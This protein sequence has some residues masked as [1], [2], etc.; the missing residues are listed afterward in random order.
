MEHQHFESSIARIKKLGKEFEILVSDAEKALQLKEKLKK[1][2][3]EKKIIEKAE[4]I[5]NLQKIC[6]VNHIFY[7]EKKGLKPTESELQTAFGTTDFFDIAAEII[8]TG[9]IVLPSELRKKLREQ[10]LK[11]M[12]D[13][14][15]KNAVDPRT[16]SL[17]PPERIEAALKQV[18]AKIDEFKSIDEQLQS[19][20]NQ[21]ARILPIKLEI[22]KLEVIIPAAFTGKAYS[23]LAKYNKQQEEWLD[24]GSLKVILNLPTALQPEFFDKLNKITNGTSL[25]KDLG[26]A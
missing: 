22:R 3:Q 24:D 7:D 18:G 11:Q 2:R 6:Q 26:E 14:L 9:E 20:I 16:K 1:I 12:I 15:S 23:F 13:F 5:E 21:L 19:I 8:E 10:K 25:T 17:H 4:L